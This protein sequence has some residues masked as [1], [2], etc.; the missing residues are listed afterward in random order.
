MATSTS[1]LVVEDES[2]VALDIS[3]RLKK[4]N[5]YVAAIVSTGESAI[6][7]ARELQPDIILMDIRL[8]GDMDGIDAATQIQTEFNIP[9][10]YLTAYADEATLQRAKI[11]TPY[12]YLLKPFEERELHTTIEMALYKHQMERRLKESENWLFT[13]LHSIGEAVIAVDGDGCVKLMNPVA[14]TLTGWTETE[15]QSQTIDTIFKVFDEQSGQPTSSA[16]NILVDNKNEHSTGPITQQLKNRAGHKI[17][18][19]SRAAPIQNKDGLWGVVLTFRDIT[20]ERAAQNRRQQQEKQAA[21]GRLAAGIAHEFNNILT[22]IIGFTE[23]TLNNPKT[24]ASLKENLGHI[25]SQGQRAAHLIQQILDFS[26]KSIINKQVLNLAPFLNHSI[27]LLNQTILHNV[28]VTI[29]IDPLCNGYQIDVD[30]EQIEQ[31]F[32]N[33]TVNAEDAMAYGGSLKF[34]AEIIQSDTPHAKTD[35][36]DRVRITISDT[37]TGIAPE[38]ISHLFEPFFTTKEVGQGTGLG[39]AQAYGIVKRHQ[40]TILIDSIEGEGTTVVIELPALPI[41]LTREDIP[42]KKLPVNLVQGQGETILLLEDDSTSVLKV[43][44][45]ALEFLGY[46]I[47]PA[48]THQQAIQLLHTHAQEINLVV[49][50]VVTPALGGIKFLHV[51]YQANYQANLL[52]LTDFPPDAKFIEQLPGTATNFLRKPWRLEELAQTVRQTLEQN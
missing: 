23:L 45:H 10:I 46:R 11:T 35:N 43:T 32:T 1:V 52:L 37:G 41:P 15:A 38:N 3:S 29:E 51:F 28:L 33:I 49:T 20:E 26:R 50:D 44:Q 34:K 8:K 4:L 22:G 12:G 6:S 17:L 9:V 48:A 5:Y 31:V 18:I 42:K 14:E 24:D 30:P 27:N 7:R 2:I 36:A 13:T 39:L 47:L 16:V 40:G 21:I 19:S 25:A